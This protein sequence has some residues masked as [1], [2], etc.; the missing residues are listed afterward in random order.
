MATIFASEH[1]QCP[2]AAAR[3][4][5]E[6]AIH[7]LSGDD[8][9][10]LLR[11]PSE[12]Y[13]V[14]MGPAIEQTVTVSLSRP[15]G[16]PGAP[17]DLHVTWRSADHIPVPAFHG[18]IGIDEAPYGCAI[19]L[20]GAYAPPGGIAGELFD[21][22]IGFWIARATVRELLVRLADSIELSFLHRPAADGLVAR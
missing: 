2:A 16:A 9:R 20:A 10:L 18:T 21:G 14:L 11:V 7:A 13:G 22:T 12:F 1:V 3:A 4:L 17:D 5:L 15:P 19:V 6:P 8:G